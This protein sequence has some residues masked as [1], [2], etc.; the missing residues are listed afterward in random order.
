MQ[1]RF[2]NRLI[3]CSDDDFDGF[4]RANIRSGQ[5]GLLFFSLIATLFFLIGIKVGGSLIIG[6]VAGAAL[7]L[8]W[9]SFRRLMQFQHDIPLIIRDRDSYKEYAGQYR[10]KDSA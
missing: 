1:S 5:I 7:Y 2:D 3:R 6:L 10:G 4:V 9:G 8:A